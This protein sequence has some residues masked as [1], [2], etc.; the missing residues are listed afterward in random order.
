MEAFQDAQNVRDPEG[1]SLTPA[2]ATIYNIPQLKKDIERDRNLLSLAIDAISLVEADDDKLKAFSV[3]I[4]EQSKRFAA[5]GKKALIFTF[6]A[7]TITYLQ[8]VLPRY[9]SE[10][11]MLSTAFIS[12]VNTGDIDSITGRFSPKSKNYTFKNGESEIMRLFATDVLSE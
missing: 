3:L 1:S 11:E 7:D 2:D 4:R 6:Y 8:N 9:L 10:E 5:S 12:G